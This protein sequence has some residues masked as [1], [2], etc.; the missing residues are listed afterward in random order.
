MLRKIKNLLCGGKKEPAQEKAFVYN[1]EGLK[2]LGSQ[3]PQKT[4]PGRVRVFLRDVFNDFIIVLTL[5]ASAGFLI[6]SYIAKPYP[7][8]AWLAFI[9]FAFGVLNIKSA[10]RSFFYGVGVGALTYMGI[11]YWIMPTVYFGTDS[12]P[13]AFAAVSGL[14]VILS[15]QF[16]FFAWCC[17]YLRKIKSALPLLAACAWAAFEFL[18]QLL[19]YFTAAFP[20]FVLGY[21]QYANVNLIQISS[22]TGAYGISFLI[23]L[24]GFCV[25]YAA[26][27]KMPKTARIAYL[28]LPL[29]LLPVCFLAGENIFIKQTKLFEQN[30]QKFMAALMQPD[31]HQFMLEGYEEDVAYSIYHQSQML[32][33]KN[34]KLALWP[35]S[36]YPGYFQEGEYYDF[37]TQLAQTYGAAQLT[38]S[39]YIK[40]GREYVSAGLFDERGLKEVYNKNKLVPFGE[41]LPLDKYFHSFYGRLGI[42]AFTGAFEPG[43]DKGKLF[44]LNFDDG[45]G[46]Q[47]VSLGPTICFESLFPVLWRAQA[48]AGAKFF[49]NISNDG[50]FLDTAAAEQH[51][52]VNIFRAAEARLPLLR[53]TNTGVSAWISPFGEV[54][55]LSPR[56][57]QDS[58][59]LAFAY[60]PQAQPTFYSKHGDLFAVI[61]LILTLSAWI[62]AAAFKA[63]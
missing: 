53:S 43:K 47:S 16:G 57:K 10:G 13:L 8:A 32:K 20:W 9:P 23:A 49:V 39:A 62:Y 56:D 52:R 28:A 29:V 11:L 46:A 3:L 21:T 24:A 17:F 30:Q 25:A 37:M 7:F 6:E 36:S 22:F 14:S 26:C 4:K 41:F 48:R 54:K 31:T 59:V 63:D 35:E 60:N 33:D 55:Y 2:L 38:G 27:G 61:C 18:H 5:F 34:V 50:W 45:R 44:T 40:D 12:K 51:L 42:N 19:A 58:A 1:T 15:L